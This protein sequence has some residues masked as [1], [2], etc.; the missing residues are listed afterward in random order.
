[1]SSS[2][3]L[4]IW[5][6]RTAMN[7]PIIA[8]MMAIQVVSEARCPPPAAAA[9][10]MEA[11]I[12]RS[13]MAV[14]TGGKGRRLSGFVCDDATGSAFRVDGRNDRHARAQLAAERSGLIEHDLHGDALHDLGEVAGRVVRREQG[15]LLSAGGRQAVHAAMDDDAGIGVDLDIDGLA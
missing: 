6:F 11:P 8:A 4:V 1:M 12:A 2:D 5:M 13:D 9:P 15:E 3:A 7:A 14:S 10:G